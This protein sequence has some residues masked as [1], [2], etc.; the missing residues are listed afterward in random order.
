MASEL[1]N[2]LRLQHLQGSI[3]GLESDQS[4]DICIFMGDLNYRM[5]TRFQHFN[6]TNIET[7]AVSLIPTHDQLGIAIKEGNYPD[8][9]EPPITFLPS[10]KL[11]N[12]ELVYIDK[13]DQAPSYCDRVLYKNNSSLKV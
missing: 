9:V 10:Y 3:L 12:T 5:N 1:V 7:E 13:K 8:Y 2:E 4:S 11:S 6:N